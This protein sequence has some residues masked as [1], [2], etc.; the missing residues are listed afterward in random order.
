MST[1]YLAEVCQE[2]KEA[3]DTSAQDEDR[4]LNDVCKSLLGM[5]SKPIGVGFNVGSRLC[6]AE[7]NKANPRMLKAKKEDLR[8]LTVTEFRNESKYKDML[9]SLGDVF[10]ADMVVTDPNKK[11]KDVE[12]DDES[13]SEAEFVPSSHSMAISKNDE[14]YLDKLRRTYKKRGELHLAE[15]SKL[16]KENSVTH[17]S[18]ERSLV[19][20]D[21]VC[22][23]VIGLPGSL[24]AEEAFSAIFG[25]FEE[26]K[27]WKIPGTLFEV[28]EGK[29]RFYHR[30]QLVPI[31]SP[32]EGIS[33]N[34]HGELRLSSDRME[35]ISH[36]PDYQEY[37]AKLKD[38]LDK[39]V[40]TIPE[41]AVL[42]MKSMLNGKGTG[43]LLK[44]I[45]QHY[46]TE[47]KVAFEAACGKQTQAVY[48]FARRAMEEDLIREL[49]FFPWP[50][51]D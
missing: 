33:I 25:I 8:A 22:I 13:D 29:N 16:Q 43:S 31:G 44:P 32:L 47:Y 40:S 4:P 26:R 23:H 49:G 24:T 18:Q 27:V 12:S 48:P 15:R 36:G 21:D 51:D 35:I 2:F 39:A 41:L 11:R 38:A 3:C 28:F 42:I 9:F 7:Y 50:L 30:D 10:A 37:K 14:F 46:A 45:S 34:Y 20:D 5:S 1:S 6:K 17:P 19:R